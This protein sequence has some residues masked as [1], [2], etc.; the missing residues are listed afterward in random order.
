[1][2]AVNEPIVPAAT[3]ASLIDDDSAPDIGAWQVLRRGI[4]TSPELKTGLAVT[5][6]LAV[7]AAAGRLVIP[8]L[9]QQILDHG[10]LGQDGYREGFV[11]KAAIAAMITVVV[12]AMASRIAFVR[13]VT[14]TESVLLDLRVRV[15]EH[16]HKLSLADH[17]ESRSGVLVARVTSDIETLVRFTQWG[18][19]SWIIDTAI[20]IGTLVV[21]AVYSWQLTLVAVA[22][23]LPLLPFLRWVQEKQFVAYGL[24]RTRVAETL[25]HTAEAVSGAPVIRAYDYGDPV[26]AR[27]DDSIDRQYQQQLR[28]SV[29]F[30]GLLPVVDFVSSVSL[31]VA[32]GIGV[33]W[34]ADLGVEVGELV[35]FI[36]LV[37]LILQPIS[38]LGE[39]LDQTQ[40]ALAGWW[41][42]LRVLDVPIAVVEPEDG[43]ELPTGPLGVELEDVSF[44]YRTGPMVLRNISLTIPPETNVA[45]VGE[46]GSGKTTTARLFARLADPIGGVVRIGGI[47]LRDVDPDSRHRSIRMV[48]QDGFLFDRWSATIFGS[49][50]VMPPMMTSSFRST[51]WACANGWSHCPRDSTLLLASEVAVFL[52]V[53]ASSSLWPVRRWLTLVYCCSMRL[54][55]RSIPRRKKHWL[56]PLAASLLVEQR[57]L[58]PTACRPRNVPILC[59]SS[60]PG[61]LSSRVRIRSWSRSR[62]S[63]VGSTNPGSVTPA[64]RPSTEQA[65]GGSG[66]GQTG[67]GRLAQVGSSQEA[68]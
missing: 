42:I 43:Q 41:K 8:I 17:T 62:G 12:V 65:I 10:I 44:R 32:M 30:A 47:D 16:I 27:L 23:H 4:A 22:V 55:Q 21:M 59:W 49:V 3:A 20:I 40:T 68:L 28:S 53:N 54:R 14:M 24:V 9:V 39:V 33:W 60:T 67:R 64:R 45:V 35:A 36:F 31:A 18:M 48:P 19:I 37:N 5:V 38:Q 7:M 25:G 15:F 6:M 1:M 13:L 11:A 50:V 57:S 58:L 61:N 2:T 46:T 52:S 34:R 26:R 29:W 66:L 51:N 63:T 56:R